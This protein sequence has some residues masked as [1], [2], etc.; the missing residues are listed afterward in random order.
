ML[1]HVN[2]L[3]NSMDIV[4]EWMKD[5]NWWMKYYICFPLY[6]IQLFS[7]LYWNFV[8]IMLWLVSNFIRYLWHLYQS[9]QL[10]WHYLATRHLKWAPN[11]ATWC[12]GLKRHLYILI[13][14][15]IVNEITMTK[16]CLTQVH[17]PLL[18][19]HEGS[20][21]RDLVLPLKWLDN[22]VRGMFY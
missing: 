11:C 18:A 5:A 15:V 7:Q 12:L 17:M 4:Y 19:S 1:H 6:L 22:D 9:L 16:K 10:S 13:F 14:E 20:I 21:F 2:Y 8:T 3:T